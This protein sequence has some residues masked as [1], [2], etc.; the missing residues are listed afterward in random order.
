[1][2]HNHYQPS[3]QNIPNLLDLSGSLGSFFM[4]SKQGK[5]FALE[6]LS[7]APD[8]SKMIPEIYTGDFNT[9]YPLVADIRPS[10]MVMV[11]HP[12]KQAKSHFLMDVKAGSM[13]KSV[14]VL[15][16]ASEV[17]SR[18]LED[19]AF[20]IILLGELEK[21]FFISRMKGIDMVIPIR[22]A[23]FKSSLPAAWVQVIEELFRANAE[24]GKEK[25]ARLDNHLELLRAT[26]EET[27]LKEY[28]LK[29]IWL[30]MDSRGLGKL[31]LD[32]GGVRF[33]PYDPH[34]RQF[35][36][37]YKAL[38]KGVDGTPQT[39]AEVAKV[40]PFPLKRFS[41]VAPTL[42]LYDQKFRTQHQLEEYY[43]LY[44]GM[45]ALT[46]IGTPVLLFNGADP[47]QGNILLRFLKISP[48]A[49]EQLQL[50]IKN[51]VRR[52]LVWNEDSQFL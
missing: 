7:A 6:R 21:A 44:S 40:I 14:K 26:I 1:M 52:E 48:F 33:T 51:F 39:Y 5:I 12:G 49:N 22:F 16:E 50:G 34:D 46:K 37:F 17:I 18:T 28:I 23:A 13:K 38:Q 36:A 20:P 8:L 42:H 31:T 10:N 27:Q 2:R 41:W 32:A 30:D 11:I 25:A 19:G 4:V 3:S 45:Q 47:L 35:F 15:E 43:S 29:C 9:L 24:L